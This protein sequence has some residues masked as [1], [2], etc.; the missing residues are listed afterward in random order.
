[1]EKFILIDIE[2]QDFCVESGIYEVAALVV[3]N[4][5][6]VDSFY[7]G[8]VEDETKIHI[9]CGIGYKNISKNI[10]CMK[11][12]KELLIKYK[13]PLM[14]HNASFDRKFLIY[15]KWIDED[16]PFYDTIRAIKYA[17]PKLLSYSLSNLRDFIG[18]EKE[19]TH[20]AMEDVELTLDVLKY[21][22][23]K[24][25]IAIGIKQKAKNKYNSST[26]SLA[27]MKEDFK[28]VND[29]FLG[30]NIVFTGKGTYTR[31]QLMELAKKCGAGIT[32]N[33]IT[34]KTNMLVVGENAGSKLEKAHKLGIEIIHMDDFYEMI[35]GVNFDKKDQ[36]KIKNRREPEILSN[37]LD[38]EYI[39][40]S[41]MPHALKTKV[42]E[43][44]KQHGGKI[45]MRLKTTTLLIYK[46]HAYELEIIEKAKNLNIKTMSLGK[47]NRHL[48][49]ECEVE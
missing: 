9:G 5:E 28:A 20:T 49:E 16:Y 23:P 7:L 8:I 46:A 10:E 15:Y 45:T 27:A 25:W 14:A 37:K 34:K 24:K 3:H 39:F 32:S 19:H 40:I 17:N 29:L 33:S 4:F 1:M 36:V 21:F 26:N 35:E 13:Y 47:F 44:I 48:L 31:N 38:G 30:K 18:I 43:L 11:Q 41:G 22:K 12:F 2:T 6:V 42:S